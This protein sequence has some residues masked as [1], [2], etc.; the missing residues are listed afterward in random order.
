MESLKIATMAAALIFAADVSMAQTPSAEEIMKRNFTTSKFADS[1]ADSTMRLINKD[2]KE[3]VREST[4]VTK[5][6][7]GTTDNQRLITFLSPSDVKGTK[8][9]LVEHSDKEDDIWIYLPALK[10]VRRLV[11]SNKKDAFAGTDFSYGDIIGYKVEEWNH[12]LVKEDKVDGKAC[13]L[14]ESTPKT[15]AVA[16]TYG[17]SK[18]TNCVEKESAVAISGESYD[19]GGTLIKKYSAK[20]V[21]KLDE[22]NNKWTPMQMEATNVESGHKTVIEF[23]NFKV[24]TG[25][26]DA[27]FTTRSLE[28]Q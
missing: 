18:R 8:N 2:G 21:K 26:S 14:I 6:I 13:W 9:L 19:A 24:N 23:K 22:K 20:D 27:V 3:R 16:E 25:V 11:A 7:S 5:L 12:K 15:P 10:K 1:T 28:K 17:V 4:G